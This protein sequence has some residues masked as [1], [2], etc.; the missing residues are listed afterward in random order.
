[1]LPECIAFAVGVLFFCGTIHAVADDKDVFMDVFSGS[2]G[3]RLVLKG[4]KIV[5]EHAAAPP[6]AL[7][8]EVSE[9]S[10]FNLS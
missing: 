4:G 6:T 1:M 9:V 7:C 5:T 2:T 10:S 3:S 8:V